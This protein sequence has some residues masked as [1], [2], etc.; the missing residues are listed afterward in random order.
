MP[1]S[2]VRAG[3]VREPVDARP[4][5]TVTVRL[6]GV[7]DP[8]TCEGTAHAWQGPPDA[9]VLVEFSIGALHQYGWLPA[10]LVTRR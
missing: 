1:P 10:A 4:P 9:A 5:V 3:A 2:A 7:T 8:V 6:A